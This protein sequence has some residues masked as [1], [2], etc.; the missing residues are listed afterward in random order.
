MSFPRGIV[1]VML[2]ILVIPYF[3]R[4]DRDFDFRALTCPL[5]RAKD[6]PI[7][8]IREQLQQLSLFVVRFLES[9]FPISQGA[10]L[11]HGYTPTQQNTD[12]APSG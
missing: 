1:G 3:A 5:D 9:E 8:F 6:A 4:L 10:R 12:Q 11:V 7:H 2:A